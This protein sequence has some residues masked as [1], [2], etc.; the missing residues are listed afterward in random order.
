MNEEDIKIGMMVRVDPVCPAS[1]KRGLDFHSAKK[2][3]LMGGKHK[4]R[5]I[6][7]TLSDRKKIVVEGWFF[8]AADLKPIYGDDDFEKKLDQTLI[9]KN[10]EEK[11]E[12]YFNPKNL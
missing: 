1:K 2:R 5:E 7:P 4:V 8:D 6:K 10:K 3:S 9:Q 11:P 12:V